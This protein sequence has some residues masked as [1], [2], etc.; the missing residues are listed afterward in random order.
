MT[1]RAFQRVG[2]LV[3]GGLALL[4]LAGGNA[5]ARPAGH[6]RPLTSKV[7]VSCDPNG[8]RI[9]YDVR[10]RTSPSP[11]GYRV[12]RALVTGI[13]EACTPGE[14]SVELRSR[15]AALAGAE[16][17]TSITHPGSA[18]VPLRVPPLAEDVQAV[19]ADIHPF[20]GQTPT[21]VN[22]S[23]ANMPAACRPVDPSRGLI[24]T[25]GSGAL[26]GSAT[27]D[28][29]L[30]LGGNDAI[31]GGAGNDC[32]LGGRGTD[33]LRGGAGRDVLSGGAGPD[34]LAGGAGPDLLSGNSGSDV[35]RGGS[36]P[37]VIRGG[38]GDD[39]L[40]GGQGNDRLLGGPGNDRL[41]G[42]AGN[43]Y[44][45]GGPGRDRFSGCEHVVR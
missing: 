9:D 31:S 42:G 43:D 7:F 2:A 37:D 23:P 12:V 24:G 35:L 40:W 13:S 22:V 11:A 26:I 44:C 4:A 19:S 3:V 20:V 16:G 45:A 17:R 21:V 14:V 6:N 38:S 15:A 1:M 39:R 41:V 34:R 30:G 5:A 27:A 18:T 33:V 29:I 32:L 25:G 10:Y 28:L 36:G 8:I